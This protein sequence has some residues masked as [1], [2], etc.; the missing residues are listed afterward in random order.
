MLSVED[1]FFLNSNIYFE[2]VIFVETQCIASLQIL[3][4]QNHACNIQLDINSSTY[5]KAT[6]LFIT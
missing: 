1:L 3:Q 6:P 4:I 2:F 5:P